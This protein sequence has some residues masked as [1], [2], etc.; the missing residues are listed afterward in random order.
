MEAD[1]HYNFFATLHP[2]PSE[3]NA[4]RAAARWQLSARLPW[5]VQV[6]GRRR[7]CFLLCSPHLCMASV[8]TATFS[9]PTS[10]PSMP[11]SVCMTSS[12]WSTQQSSPRSCRHERRPHTQR[13]P[14]AP[15]SPVLSHPR[16]RSPTPRCRVAVCARARRR[17]CLQRRPLRRGPLPLLSRPPSLPL[18]RPPLVRLPP[19]APVDDPLRPRAAAQ[20]PRS[21]RQGHPPLPLPPPRPLPA[22]PR[23]PVTRPPPPRTRRPHHRHLPPA[24]HLTS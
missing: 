11:Q 3:C 6:S 13:V 2:L 4:T 10:L 15:L 21:R 16:R 23:P 9:A 22:Q 1:Q 12:T 17:P 19:L 14:P 24:L 20:S 5:R 18:R 8:V 7:L